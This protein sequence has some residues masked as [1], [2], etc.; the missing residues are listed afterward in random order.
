MQP[1]KDPGNQA[2]SLEWEL[3]LRRYQTSV[4]LPLLVAR[5]PMTLGEERL[6]LKQTP[7]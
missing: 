3:P 1:D 5:N 7:K 6:Q 4:P 2:G